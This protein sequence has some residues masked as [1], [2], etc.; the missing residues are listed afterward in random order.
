MAIGAFQG[1]TVGLIFIGEDIVDIVHRF[2]THLFAVG[3]C[4]ALM[5]LGSYTID[6]SKNSI[7]YSIDG[8]FPLLRSI[9][10]I[11]MV[12]IAFH[13]VSDADLSA[14]H[15]HIGA[16]EQQAVFAAT[17]GRGGD[18]S[19]TDVQIGIVHNTMSDGFVVGDGVGQ[20]LA[21]AEHPA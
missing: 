18:K 5:E 14:R 15:K 7:S 20:A 8:S 6:V 16:V 11:P 19:S 4:V 2:V 17:I 3:P 1:T 10:G 13:I 12:D 21:A 9:D